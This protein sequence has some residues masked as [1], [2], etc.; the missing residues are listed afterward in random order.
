MP[1]PRLVQ[2]KAEVSGAIAQNA[3][4][5]KDR[6]TPKRRRPLGEPYAAMTEGQCFYWAE[7][8][9]EMPWLSSADRLLVRMACQLAARMDEGDIGISAS[10][11]LAGILSKLGATPTDITKVQHGNDE[12]EDPDEHHFRPN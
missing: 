5:F 7:F 9:H 6:K 11:A 10:S 2:E 12:D 1:R 8:Q 3:G 4:R